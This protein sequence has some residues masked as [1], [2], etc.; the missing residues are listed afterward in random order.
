MKYKRG[1]S[2]AAPG[3]SVYDKNIE[4]GMKCYR[5]MRSVGKIHNEG[6]FSQLAV[7]SYIVRVLMKGADDDR[8]N[9]SRHSELRNIYSS[10]AEYSLTTSKLTRISRETSIQIFE[11]VGVYF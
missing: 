4:L 10:I 2:S 8:E 5:T 1:L 9:D 7:G 11:S 3:T 6:F